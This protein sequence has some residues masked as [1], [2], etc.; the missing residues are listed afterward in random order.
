MP[1]KTDAQPTAEELNAENGLKIKAVRH[2][3]GMSQLAFAALI[4]VDRAY[5]SELENGRQTVQEW[6]LDKAE[7]IEREHSE[8]YE[9]AHAS[10]SGRRGASGASD[11]PLVLEAIAAGLD[12]RVLMSAV[13]RITANPRISVGAKSLCAQMLGT[14]ARGVS[15]PRLPSKIHGLSSELTAAQRA[16]A[17]KQKALGQSATPA[18]SPSPKAGAPSAGK[19]KP[20]RGTPRR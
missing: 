11:L 2:R 14:K 16:A 17:K 10:G 9:A 1:P 13:Q 15:G 6:H 7:K 8:N 5:L 18:P 20:K 19:A 12:A 4:P 3:L